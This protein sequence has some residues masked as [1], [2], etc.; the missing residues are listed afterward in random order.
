M[1][2]HGCFVLGPAG[3]G[4]ST[5]CHA[6]ELHAHAA[7]RSVTFVNLDPASEG[8]PFAAS[9]DVRELVKSTELA[10]QMELGPN[11]ALIQSIEY[12]ADNLQWLYDALNDAG[13]S[14]DEFF[15]FDCP[16]QIE[17]YT[18]V[19]AMRRIC[20]GLKTAFALQLCGVFL[21]DAMMVDGDAAK[22]LSAVLLA[23]SSMLQLELPWVNVLS[24]VDLFKKSNQRSRAAMAAA[25]DDDY[26]GHRE[27]DDDEEDGELQD[28][29]DVD[30]VKVAAALK[31]PGQ[32]AL[33]R[34]WGALNEALCDMVQEFSMVRFV[35]LSSADPDSVA[36]V[37][38]HIDFATQYGEDVE[39]VEVRD[40][41]VDDDSA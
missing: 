15:V 9:V 41:A 34:K 26:D 35:A 4:K 33:E 1:G 11:G 29:L 27:G 7:Q 31:R 40:D 6:L 30:F 20:D 10:Q 23:T 14:E 19:P 38:Q 13:P 28:M 37:Q 5:F 36:L 25:V 39:P 16:G 18:H 22:Y 3:S 21:V 32:T 12:L 17:L 24:K 2:R 8:F